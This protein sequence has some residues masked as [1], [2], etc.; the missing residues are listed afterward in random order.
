MS[1]LLFSIGLAVAAIAVLAKLLDL[2]LGRN[3]KEDF[4]N[5]I[6]SFQTR[7]TNAEPK[8]VVLFPMYLAAAF[9]NRLLGA[10][11]FSMT[12]FYRTVMLTGCLGIRQV[13]PR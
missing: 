13:A 5:S 8:T 4:Q 3:K 10:R 7:F 2:F 6:Q 11:V 1:S 12:A 9:Y